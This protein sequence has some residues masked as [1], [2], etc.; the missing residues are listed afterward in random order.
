MKVLSSTLADSMQTLGQSFLIAFYLPALL[1]FL[2]HVYVL[3]PIW[4]PMQAP[5]TEEPPSTTLAT[6]MIEPTTGN[7]QPNRLLAMALNTWLCAKMADQPDESSA[8]W[9]ESVSDEAT[10]LLAGLL[11]P[12]FIGL[13]LLRLNGYLIQGFEGK[14]RILKEG[15]LYFLTK[16][17]RKQSQAL[18]AELI[19]TQTFYREVS[20]K[21]WQSESDNKKLTHQQTLVSLRAKID[22]LHNQIEQKT[23]IQTLPYDQTRIGP[24]RFGNYYAVAEEYSYQRY[25]AD[26][27]LFWTRLSERMQDEA[28]EHS[29]RLIQQKTTL[30]FTLNLT[31][32]SVLLL[33]EAMFTLLGLYFYDQ[34]ADW[35]AHWP[36]FALIGMGIPL[37]VLL[38][39]S[40]VGA[41]YLLGELIKN[42]FDHYRHLILTSFGL[43]LPDT[44]REEQIIWVRLAAFIRR[45]DEFYFPT[46]FKV[47]I[48]D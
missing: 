20:H 48:K 32:L 14:Y 18:Y 44:L 11:L 40:S 2:L 30:D 7:E 8:T 41:V 1:F 10:S 38:Y 39:Y 12:F 13:I 35:W 15:I 31:F 21:L 42:S 26:A 23:P 17:N 43:K 33:I 25:G 22:E 6:C 29:E 34:P 3:F 46:E 9:V 36:L 4:Q 45:G 16:R 19:E 47:S 27:V 5:P 28:P 24:T 37:A